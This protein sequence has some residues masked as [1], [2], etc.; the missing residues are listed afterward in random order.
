MSTLY[1]VR[2]NAIIYSKSPHFFM[3]I[4]YWFTS[5]AA[6]HYRCTLAGLFDGDTDVVCRPVRFFVFLVRENWSPYCAES[7]AYGG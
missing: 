7:V 2:R 6:G 5:D 1:E 3:L 4:I